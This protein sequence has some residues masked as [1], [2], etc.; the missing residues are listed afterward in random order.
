MTVT[1]VNDA[2]ADGNIPYTIVTAPRRAATAN[3]TGCDPID[4][5]VTNIDN[6]TAGIIVTPTSGLT[7]TEAGGTATFAVRAQHAADRRR[8]DRADLERHDGGHGQ[9]VE[10][11]VHDQQLEYSRRPSPSPAST[12]TSRRRHRLHHRHGAGGEQRRQLQRSQRQRCLRHQHRQ[13]HDGI[14][15][16]PTSG[17]TTTEAGG[18]ATFTIALDSAPTAN[19]TIDLSSSNTGEGTRLQRAVTF[20]P[21]NWN[22]PQRSRLPA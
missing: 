21:A 4:V 2:L 15:V 14:T 12:T 11:H 20:T 5:T 22:S 9:S 19:V 17:L 8:D 7:T 3:T 13:R 18:T 10:P 16:T 6:N 1:G